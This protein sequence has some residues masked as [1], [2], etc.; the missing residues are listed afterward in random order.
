MEMRLSA[1][2]LA[3]LIVALTASACQSESAVPAADNPAVNS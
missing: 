1:V 2:I 3:T